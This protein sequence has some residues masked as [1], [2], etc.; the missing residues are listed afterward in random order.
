MERQSRCWGDVDQPP[1]QNRAHGDRASGSVTALARNAKGNW[2]AWERTPPG[3]ILGVQGSRL[4][5]AGVCD[6]PDRPTILIVNLNE[7]PFS[8]D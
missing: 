3:S 6:G 5:V 8:H 4:P 2:P 1:A 7:E